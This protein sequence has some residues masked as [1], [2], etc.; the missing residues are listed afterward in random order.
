M[1][2]ARARYET[3]LPASDSAAAWPE[4]FRAA[5]VDRL[6]P[7]QHGI[8]SHAANALHHD[9]VETLVLAHAEH[10]NDVGVVQPRGG[11]RLAAEA[12]QLLGVQQRLLG[13]HLDGDVPV[14]RLLERLVDNAHAAAA[15]LADD[16]EIAQPFQSHSA[17]RGAGAV[18]SS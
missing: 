8:Q 14:E 13:Q 6:Q 15:D 2:I 9:V 7:V 16:A 3:S 18:C 10:G 5:G 12:L 1:S 11:L 17:E 4:S